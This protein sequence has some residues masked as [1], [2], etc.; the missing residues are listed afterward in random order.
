MVLKNTLNYY[1]VLQLLVKVHIFVLD[2]AQCLV[3]KYR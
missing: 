1:E 2:Q 3:L